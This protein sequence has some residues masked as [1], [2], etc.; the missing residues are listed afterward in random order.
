MYNALVVALTDDK[1]VF[2]VL[3]RSEYIAMLATRLSHHCDH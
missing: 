2:W 1:V 3:G